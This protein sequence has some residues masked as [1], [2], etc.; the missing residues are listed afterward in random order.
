MLLRDQMEPLA[1]DVA[2][3]LSTTGASPGSAWENYHLDEDLIVHSQPSDTHLIYLRSTNHEGRVELQDIKFEDIDPENF[4]LGERIVLASELK[5]SDSVPFKNGTSLVQTA[6]LYHEEKTGANEFTAIMAG[7]EKK[8]TVTATAKAGIGVAEAEAS[9]VDETTLKAEFN[10]QTGR[11]AESTDGGRFIFN[12]PPFTE[13][14]A[15][16]TWTEQTVQNRIKGYR[17]VR[18]KVVIGR[19]QDYRKTIGRG[20]AKK[21]IRRWTSGSPLTWPDVSDLIAV[22]EKRGS[23]K[24]PLFEHYAGREAINPVYANRLRVRSRVSIDVLTEPYK[25]ANE[26]RPE[27]VVTR[28]LRDALEIEAEIGGAELL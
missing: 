18:C 20:P 7:F 23:V 9:V 14:E 5:A 11:S 22:I 27:I 2:D 3:L 19:Y 26:F 10:R 21:R 16:L 15:R 28:S 1:R 6:E 12:Q 17:L 25:G 13:G 4:S 8:V 24:H